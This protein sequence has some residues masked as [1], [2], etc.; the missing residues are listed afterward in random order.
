NTIMISKGDDIKEYQEHG[1]RLNPKIYP[2]LKQVQENRKNIEAI[3]DKYYV[4]TSFNGVNSSIDLYDT[5]ILSE[6]GDYVEFS[7]KWLGD[8]YRDGLGIIGTRGGNDNTMGF[9]SET[10]FWIRSKVGQPYIEF[11]DI[12]NAKESLRVYKVEVTDDCKEYR[13]YIDGV[14]FGT[15]ILEEST[16]FTINNI[17]Q[18]YESNYFKGILGFV[19]IKSGV[20]LKTYPD[21]ISIGDH[22]NTDTNLE[23][24][25]DGGSST[26]QPNVFVEFS[27][28]G[29][30]GRGLFI[31]YT[32]RIGSNS[33]VGHH[34]AND[35]NMIDAAYKDL[36]RIMYAHEYIYENGAMVK[37]QDY[38]IYE[39]E[40]EFVIRTEGDRRDHTGGTHG[41]EIKQN[42]AF[43]VDGLKI[44]DTTALALKPCNEAMYMQTSTLHYTPLM[45]EP[46]GNHD[47]IANHTKKTTFKSG[48]YYTENKLFGEV[49][50]GLPIRHWYCGIC[51][52]GKIQASVVVNE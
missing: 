26:S 46:Y 28:D 2:T 50:G 38:T 11:N 16:D 24:K 9:S 29:F 34:V 39:G 25:D 20:V 47:V 15:S 8:D 45:S 3:L 17:G 12:P 27:P 49:E 43:F 33:Y 48:C 22:T 19:N 23:P 13:L 32:K 18:T 36:Y 42:V 6:D 21:L 41:D 10:R 1:R 4:L 52:V 35:Y 7:A 14:L 37:V 44:D 31:V 51:C 30:N 5:S 40:S